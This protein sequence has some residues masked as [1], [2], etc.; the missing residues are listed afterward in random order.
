[1]KSLCDGADYAAITEQF[2]IVPMNKFWE[3]GMEYTAGDLVQAKVSAVNER[4]ESIVSQANTI[5]A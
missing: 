3:V 2:C 4:G 1:M 5:G